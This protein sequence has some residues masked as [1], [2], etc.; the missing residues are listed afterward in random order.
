MTR[1]DRIYV[2]GRKGCPAQFFQGETACDQAVARF[3]QGGMSLTV[4][5]LIQ[6]DETITV[7][8]ADG[9]TLCAINPPEDS[10]GWTTEYFPEKPAR[11]SGSHVSQNEALSWGLAWAI[12]QVA[13]TVSRDLLQVRER[14]H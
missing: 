7:E 1:R 11:P 13:M 12:E 3:Q 8:D 4:L 9:E 14:L 6:D 10:P 5:W 2:V